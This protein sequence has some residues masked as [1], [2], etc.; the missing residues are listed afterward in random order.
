MDISDTLAPKSD[1]LNAEDLLTSTRT[2]T[3]EK[4]VRKSSDEQPLDVD[5]TEF[6]GR[7]FRPSKTV[8]RILAAVWGSESDEGR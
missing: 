5:L 3:I 4:V 1:Q 7:P 2:V 8:R 6:P